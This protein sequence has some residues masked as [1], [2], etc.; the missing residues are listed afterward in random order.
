MGS[1]RF[2]GAG[3][4]ACSTAAMLVLWRGSNHSAVGA[5][6]LGGAGPEVEPQ[7]RD[8]P[9]GRTHNDDASSDVMK[10]ERSMWRPLYNVMARNL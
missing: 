3:R 2:H 10:S 7:P 9:P 1:W 5:G 6:M 8:M 4:E